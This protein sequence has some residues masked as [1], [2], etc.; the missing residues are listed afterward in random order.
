MSNLQNKKNILVIMTGSIACYKACSVISK[1]HQSGYNLQVVMSPSSLNFV[2]AA[3]IEGLTGQTPITDMYASGNVM[4]HIQLVRWADLILVAPATANYINKIAYGIGDDLLTTLFL[5]HDFEKPFLIAPAMNTKMYLHPV[6]QASINKL[7]AMSVEIL[8]AASGVLACGEI[9]SGRLL[10]PEMIVAEVEQRIGLKKST[11]AQPAKTATALKVLITA[12]GTTEPIDDVRMISNRSSGRTAATLADALTEAGFAVTYLHSRSAV[13]PKNP[14]TNIS[15][16]S[17]HDLESLLKNQLQSHN[18]HA[19]LHAAAVS[20]YSVAP[21][22]GKIDSSADE[23]LLVLKKNPKLLNEIKKLSPKSLL[24]AFKLT[25]TVDEKVIAD[26]VAALFEK[27]KAD[28][29]VQNNWNDIK[30]K[31]YK[32]RLYSKTD[33]TEIEA[34]QSLCSTLFQKIMI[35]EETIL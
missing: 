29:V 6:T 18:F 13:L 26:K 4:D 25:S 2:G 31:N 9:G 8:E 33:Y 7:K 28:F 3:T 34:L 17:F 14:S 27:A 32:Y 30:N 35:H 1:L 22:A 23:I 10:E 19:V 15:F 5:A 12:G 20:D 24:I 11:P 16:D 21:Q